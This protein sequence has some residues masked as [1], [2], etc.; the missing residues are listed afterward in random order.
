MLNMKKYDLA[1]H[2]ADIADELNELEEETS[3]IKR[4]SEYSDIA[5]TY[6]RAR[7]TGYHLK[8][9]VSIFYFIVGLIYMFPKYTSRWLF[10]RRVGK[11]F[12]KVIHEVRN[13]NKT[14]KLHIIA[15]RAGINP[16]LF[17]TQCKKQLRYWPLLK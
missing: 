4:W 15:H 16:E 6:T 14:E 13:P 12:G 8:R 7:W 10:F 9:P 2:K 5:Y 1:W 17:T 11:K 3:W